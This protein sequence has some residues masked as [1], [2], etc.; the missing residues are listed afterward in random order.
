M[1]RSFDGLALRQLKTRPLRAFLTAFGVVLGVGMV[2]GVLLLVGTIRF[3]FDNLIESSFGKQELIINAKAGYL[4][5]SAL[6]KVESTAGVTEVGRMV[7]AQFKRLGPDGDPVDGLNGTIMVAGVDPYA[8]NPYRLEMVAGREP[9]F[10]SEMTVQRDWAKSSGVAVGDRVRVATPSGP[11]R[12][13]VVGFFEMEGGAS[14]GDMGLGMMPLREARRVMQIPAGW[15]QLTASVAKASEL[16]PV[17]KRLETKLGDGV[18][19]KTPQGWSEQ[20]AAQFDALNMILY[21]FSGIALFVGGFLI[22]NNFNMTVLQRM[23]EIGMLRTLG[24][25]R[26]TVAR[27]VLLEAMIIGAIGTLFGLGLGLALAL[28]LLEMMRGLG[29]P[30]DELRV[31]GGAAITAVV[32]GLV[33]TAFGAFWPAR[34][35]GRIPPIRAALGDGATRKRPSIR[36][37]L[38]GL[39]L[40]LPG[41]ILGGELFMGGNSAGDALAGMVVTLLMFVGMT[42][43]APFIILP[44]IA[45]MAPVFRK[46]FPAS[47]RLAVDALRSN[48]TRTAATAAALTVGLSVV[49]V[50]SSMASS[51]IGSIRDQLTV[52]FARDFNLQAQGGGVEQGGGTGL[53]ARLRAEVTRMPE[54]AVA[55]PI[56]AQVTSMP[57][58][59]ESGFLVAVDP[60][61]YPQ[62]DKTP[63]DG[64]QSREY[65]YAQ[66]VHG[67]IVV[68]ANYANS[69][70]WKVGD[71]VPLSG[72]RGHQNSQV[73]GILG[74]A[75]PF[76]ILMSLATMREVYGLETDAILAIK[77]KSDAVVPALQRKLDTLI[78][79][80][81]QNLELLSQADRRQEIE[82]MINQQF[83]FFNAI[84]AIAVIV[85]LLGVVNT[86][87]MSVIERTRE[88]GVMRALGSSRWLVRQTMLD[89]S[90]MMTMAGAIAGVAAGL[91][92]GFVWVGSVAETMGGVTFHWPLGTMIGVTI[93]AVI[94]GVIA[95]ALPARRA[96]RLKVIDALS[97]E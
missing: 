77:A 69:A 93:A 94:A 63:I 86:L 81:Y 9:T 17:Q 12:L 4:P 42:L 47:G 80:R 24:A 76:D 21:F 46:V 65:A 55:T 60:M 45:A 52:N 57:K 23:R 25:S 34:R 73:V 28:G 92:I 40:F 13:K 37:G 50:N 38:L 49:V 5:Q 95:A 54:V 14:W 88:I 1:L 11:M 62:V 85:S 51:F 27:T 39:A 3:T 72:P 29:M 68:G 79:E 87:A 26:G 48:A 96:A 36:R 89:E 91:L 56:R 78:D 18:D 8:K 84:V 41:L 58:T 64:T 74:S 20:V 43:A 53:P 31:S 82:D 70:G 67:G 2:F 33:V 44:L 83:N 59:E 75:E 16:E 10:G 61:V 7:G 97:Y 15:V 22:L 71:I 90:L 66:M 32:L 19:V 35:A 6:A 30:V